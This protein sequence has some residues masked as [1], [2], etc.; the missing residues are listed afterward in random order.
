LNKNG[1]ERGEYQEL[2]SRVGGKGDG[3]AKK[4]ENGF[5]EQ[6]KKAGGPG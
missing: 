2:T 3:G 6:H 4:R 5:E 1:G